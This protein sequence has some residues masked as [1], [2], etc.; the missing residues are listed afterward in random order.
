MKILIVED[1]MDT[2][3]ILRALLEQAGYQIEEAKSGDEGLKV[4]EKETV[5]EGI[6]SSALDRHS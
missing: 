5:Y 4:I 3:V 6:W 1:E 2:R